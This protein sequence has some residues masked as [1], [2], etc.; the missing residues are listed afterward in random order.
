MI[1]TRFVLSCLLLVLL[2]SCGNNATGISPP[3][4]PHDPVN[5]AWK[6]VENF[7]YSYNTQDIDLL[8]ITLDP[9]FMHHLEEEYWDDYDGDGII[10]TYLDLDLE[11][12]FTEAF[13][14]TAEMIELTLNGDDEQTWPDDSLAWALELPRVYGMKVYYDAGG[15]YQGSQVSGTISFI[16]RPD[17]DEEWR[18]WQLFMQPSIWWLPE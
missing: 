4:L 17:S 1:Y 15:P 5:A 18:I 8:G 2:C 12:L 13:F 9:D 10:D 16:C 6:A 7:Q 14:D 3:V 11:L